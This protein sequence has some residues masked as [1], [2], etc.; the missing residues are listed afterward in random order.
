MP[1]HPAG[2]RCLQRPKLGKAGRRRQQDGKDTLCC[3][4][5][6]PYGARAIWS[7][8]HGHRHV[9]WGMGTPRHRGEGGTQCLPAL[10]ATEGQRNAWKLEAQSSLTVPMLRG[11]HAGCHQLREGNAGTGRGQAG[12]HRGQPGVRG[13]AMGSPVLDR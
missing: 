10:A 1:V 4:Q 5:Q 11:S 2:A 6:E 13:R 12:A 7:R 8:S 9:C 3:F